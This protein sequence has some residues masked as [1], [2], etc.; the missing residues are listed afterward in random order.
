MLQVCSEVGL[1]Q[2][3]KERPLANLQRFGNWV[4][5]VQTNLRQGNSVDAI[6]QMLRD[7]DYEQWLMEQSSSPKVAEKRMENV[8]HL[9]NSIER[10][11]EKNEDDDIEAVIGKLVL[12]DLLE[13]QQEDDDSDRVQLMTLHAS[14]GLE[15]PYV[16][17]VGLEE[18]ILPH[19]SSIEEDTIEEERRLMYVGI[20]RA[21][22]EL[23][24]TL[25]AKRKQYGE[26]FETTPSRFL[27]EIPSE[28]LL[29]EGRGETKS[30]EEK[31]SLG[32][33]HLAN[34]RSLL[35]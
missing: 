23:T 14:K 25:A 7:V 35:D 12:L 28:D 31:Q 11:L 8:M 4:D 22:K 5:E 13:Q 33:A 18:E 6:K 24:L 19:R 1:T 21:K 34:I 32:Q 9:V 27:D 3:L 15:F 17:L 30:K 16:F 29:W 10:M 2:H 26:I 20:T